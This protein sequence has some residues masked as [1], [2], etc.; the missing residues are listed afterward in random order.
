[1]KR[2]IPEGVEAPE[3]CV[4]LGWGGTFNAPAKGFDG[5]KLNNFPHAK[6]HFIHGWAGTTADCLYAADRLSE[7]ARLNREAT[8]GIPADLDQE[9]ADRIL[10]TLTDKDALIREL[11]GALEGL[12]ERD[13]EL[14]AFDEAK[15]IGLGEAINSARSVVT[16]ARTTCPEDFEAN[17]S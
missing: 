16:L 15:G 2:P 4:I 14:W 1:M 11:V 3:G 12:V 8:A 10:K 7:V 6:W 5:W 17:I 13:R 9:F